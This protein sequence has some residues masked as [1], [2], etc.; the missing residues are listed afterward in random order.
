MS[1]T[2]DVTMAPKAAPITTATARSTILVIED[3][4][5]SLQAL[6]DVLTLCGARVL[7]AGDTL[8]ARAYVGTV[9]IDLVVTD[10]ALPGESG[11]AFVAWLRQQPHDKGGGVAAIAITSSP[12]Q[13]AGVRLGG[14]A[15]YLPQPLGPAE[16]L[17]PVRTPL[18]P[19]P[20]PPRP[21]AGGR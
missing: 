19:G 13:F 17:A 15:P 5:D 18:R 21:A 12:H 16:P 10:L 6:A 14:L 1:F 4:A 11:A 3:Q 8:D 20:R 2:N 9:K 7:M